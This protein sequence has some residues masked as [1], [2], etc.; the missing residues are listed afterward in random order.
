MKIVYIA[1]S[2]VPG[3]AANSV[4]VMKMCEAFQANEVETHLILPENKTDKAE[5]ECFSI[6]GINKKFK[7][8][9]VR[10][11]N[12]PPAGIWNLIFS[13][14]AIL[15]AIKICP[16]FYYTRN[17]ITAKLLSILKYPFFFEYHGIEFSPRYSIEQV[18][19]SP[20]LLK[21]IVI[22]ESLKAYYVNRFHLPEDRVI[23]LSDGVNCDNFICPGDDDLLQREQ[24]RIGYVGGLYKGRG[25]DIVIKLACM[26]LENQ[27]TI[28]GGRPE[29]I[30]EWKE[31]ACSEGAN[32]NFIGHVENAK[33]PEL[34]FG[35]DILLMPY[36]NKVQ[37]NGTEDTAKWMSPMKMFEYMASKRVI[38]SSDLPVLREVLTDGENA[39]L[40]NPEDVS[41][42]Y[43]AIQFIHKN[44]EKA[45]SIAEQAHRDVRK[46]DWYYRAKNIIKLYLESTD[47]KY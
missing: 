13:I 17:P 2:S 26:D 33:V 14:F 45:K 44:R 28:A 19:N 35:E 41:Q 47:T 9:R 32:I 12:H 39:I 30:E 15:K 16:D 24:L 20:N 11:W 4:H 6:Y 36:Q 18:L 23:V 38:I 34:L 25:I 10:L 43:D 40:V 7:I 8:H 31:L 37:V 22:T 1:N 5:A 3:M 29:Q 46:Y 27:Y 42:W 21:L